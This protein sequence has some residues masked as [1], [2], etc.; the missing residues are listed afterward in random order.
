M[1]TTVKIMKMVKIVKMGSAYGFCRGCVPLMKMVKIVE[2]GWARGCGK[3][4]VP[5]GE[6]KKR[7]GKMVKKPT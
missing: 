4:C 1:C 7:A 6:K 2:M 3:G 5:R